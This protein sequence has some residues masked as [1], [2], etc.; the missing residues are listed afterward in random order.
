MVY[1]MVM[2]GEASCKSDGQYLHRPQILRF[3]DINRRKNIQ[4]VAA[5]LFYCMA[6]KQLENREMSGNPA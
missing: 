4:D 3:S 1:Y 2:A 5:R 6:Y